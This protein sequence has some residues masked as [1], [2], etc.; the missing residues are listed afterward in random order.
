MTLLE[1]YNAVVG[2]LRS[3]V[4]LCSDGDADELAQH[5][6]RLAEKT[7]SDVG[8]RMECEACV[9]GESTYCGSFCEWHLADHVAECEVCA[10]DF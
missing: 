7:L 9:N 1:K 10:R 5:V 4:T 8:E 6:A 3:V 2:T